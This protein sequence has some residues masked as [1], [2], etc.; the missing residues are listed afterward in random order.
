[1]HAVRPLGRPEFPVSAYQTLSASSDE[2]S[3]E[4]SDLPPET[5]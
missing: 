3:S 4:M 5:Y 2:F 1:M